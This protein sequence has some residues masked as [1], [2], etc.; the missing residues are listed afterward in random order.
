MNYPSRPF[1]ADFL[2]GIRLHTPVPA[3]A[4]G[5]A[6]VGCSRDTAIPP[7]ANLCSGMSAKTHLFW[8]VTVGPSSG[9]H[10]LPP[11]T[12]QSEPRAPKS[13]SWSCHA[14]PGL[15]QAQLPRNTGVLW[16]DL[17]LCQDQPHRVI[18]GFSW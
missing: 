13:I 3:P 14:M 2:E 1:I 6:A 7:T 8:G 5:E 4:P 18:L 12:H 17:P 9:R 16:Q 15:P 10:P 11:Y